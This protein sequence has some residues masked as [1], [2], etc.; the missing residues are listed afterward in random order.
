MFAFEGGCVRASADGVCEGSTRIV[1][2]NKRSCDACPAKCSACRIPDFD[3]ASTA[4][5]LQCM[6]CIPDSFLSNEQS[7]RA[8]LGRSFRRKTT[9]TALPGSACSPAPPTPSPPQPHARRATP[10]APRAPAAPS[11]SAVAACQGPPSSPTDAA[12]PPAPNCSSSIAHLE[13]VSRATLPARAALPRARP[14]ASHI[15]TT[16]GSCA[17]DGAS[18][19]TAM[20]ARLSSLA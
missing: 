17:Q 1:D 10:T 19:R 11:I 7:T 16:H 6:A 20:A 9:S 2:N 4:G 15:Q 18:L 12:S 3:Q 8:P 14:P 13:L 5:K